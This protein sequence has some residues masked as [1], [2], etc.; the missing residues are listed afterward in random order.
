[1][2]ARQDVDPWNAD[3]PD[4][5]SQE[6]RQ[7]LIERQKKELSLHDAMMEEQKAKW[8]KQ[9]TKS[10]YQDSVKTNGLIKGQAEFSKDQHIQN[11]FDRLTGPLYGM[12]P[13][14]AMETISR[15]I[16]SSGTG[17]SDDLVAARS[18]VKKVVQGDLRLVDHT[19]LPSNVQPVQP[20]MP[21]QPVQGWH[22]IPLLPNATPSGEKKIT[23]ANDVAPPVNE[24]GLTPAQALGKEGLAK[25][26]MQRDMTSMKDP[27]QDNLFVSPQ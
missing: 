3:G 5:L 7:A 16:Q 11:A 4:N 19:P 27:F 12:S 2:N 10:R 15:T 6:S 17:T 13:G 24:A 20:E 22:G 14:E 9:D 26:S 18:R 25:R 21:A 8:K 1:M 23:V